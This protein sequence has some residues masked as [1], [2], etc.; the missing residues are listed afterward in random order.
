MNDD[1]L[2]LIL[3]SDILD[4]KYSGT[5]DLGAL[6]AALRSNTLDSTIPAYFNPEGKE[7]AAPPPT[8]CSLRAT[9]HDTE[10]LLAFLLPGLKIGNGTALNVDAN[11]DGTILGYVTAP[12]LQWNDIHAKNLDVA[13][14][15][16]GGSLDGTVDADRLQIGNFGLDKASFSASASEDVLGLAVTYQNADLLEG[17]GE[18]FMNAAFERTPGD[19]LRINVNTLPSQIDIKSN[20]WEIGQALITLQEGRAYTDGLAIASGD[21]SIFLQGGVR[22]DAAD[23][24]RV[25]FNELDLDIVNAF[26]GNV[27]GIKGILQGDATLQSPL[28]QQL[29]LSSGLDI[30][31]LV[32]SGTEAGDISL[33]SKWDDDAKAIAVNLSNMIDGVKGLDLTG[34][35]GMKDGAVNAT[36]VFDHFDLGIASSFVK[37]ILP[38]IGGT[39]SG[40]LTAGGSANDLQLASESLQLDGVRFRVGYTN[41]AYTLDGTM[42]I[43]DNTVTFNNI[44]AKDDFGGIGVL[45]GNLALGNFKSPVLNASMQMSSLKALNI[46]MGESGIGIYGDLA[47]S[48]L[49][50]VTGPFNDLG[51][52][53]YISTAG[54]GSVNV[55]LS[56]SMAA[57]SGDLLTFVSP[58]SEEVVDVTPERTRKGKLTIHARA[59]LSPDVTANIEIDKDSGH[60]LTAG[61]NGTVV[62]DYNTA[63]DKMQLNGD[64]LIDK[65]KY[66][67][68]IPGIVSKEFDIKEGSALKFNGDLMESTLDI[69]A[70][71]NVKT[72][73]ATLLAD[74]TA[75]ST[76]R[77]VVCGL[78]ISGKLRSPEVS[79]NI[80]VPD[81]E[82][83]TKM[84]V[85][86]ALSTT[87]KVQK[88]FVALLLFGTFLPEENA[89]IVN[90]SN[91]LYANVG[92]IVAGQLNNILQKLDIPVDFGFGYQQDNAGTDMFDVAVSTQLFNNRLVVGGSVGNRKYS[93]SKS[94][95]GD[96]VGDLDIE[97]KLDR[98]GELR[99]KLFSHSADEYTSSLDYSQRNGLGLSY[100]K[101]FDRW[102]E[103]FKQ[104][105]TSKKRRQE[106]AVATGRR[107]E[108]KRIEI[109]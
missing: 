36:A 92:E 86:A 81:L 108:V 74:S 6:A 72:T 73:L 2:M 76:R 66:L 26:T 11:A 53:A 16:L 31:D 17:G 94:A 59:T 44:G 4:A 25:S 34:S 9:F 107:R 24:L 68:N 47:I 57:S 62:F 28:S 99:F 14:G 63:K 3:N 83:N 35:Y 18:V 54:P 87:D 12:E 27:L 97:L 101:E 60:V 104:L 64:Y 89:G 69:K 22:Q 20:T 75:V 7:T 91:M 43:A 15:N 98:S 100:Q 109:E 103:F 45:T 55:P 29:A 84:Q 77:T 8:D 71:H 19:S 5:S 39:L 106:T 42:S 30:S 49:G 105:F 21:Q 51:V 10:G 96:I 90:G 102:P 61:G 56:S 95:N 23:S 46:P 32:I 70:T 48:G 13:L 52:N 93:T 78:N 1:N 50:R 85:D 41:V 40:T 88:Q 79:F 38:E 33:N 37:D 80:D 58:D 67:L 65:G 82:P